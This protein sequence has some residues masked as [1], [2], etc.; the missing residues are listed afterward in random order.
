M[1]TPSSSTAIARPAI[2]A[3][4]QVLDERYRILSLLAEGGMGTVFL[5]EHVLIKRRV[6]IK[7]LHRELA[8]DSAMVQRFMN[9]AL[10]AGTLGHPNI[11]ESTDMGFTPDRVPYIV[12]EYLEGSLLTEEIYRVHG[13][14]IR[15]ALR[16]AIQ[17]AS[18]LDAAHNAG[19]VHLDLKSDNVFLT[20]KD[21]ELDHV[22]VLDFGISRFM[23]PDRDTTQRGLILGTPEFMAPEQVESPDTVDH[24]ADVY[25]LGVLLYE[26]LG[27]RR[28]FAGDDP[29]ILLYRICNEPPPRLER[30]D[31]MPELEHVLFD[32]MLAKQRDARFSSMKEVSS[33]LED[34]LHSV[35]AS[36]SLSTRIPTQSATL[37]VTPAPLP[38]ASLPTAPQ[39]SRVPAMLAI[40]AVLGVLAGGALQF[41]GSRLGSST[42]DAARAALQ[43]DAEDI[44]AL[45]ASQARAARTRADSLATTP[46]L[47]AAIETDA[48]TIADLIRD[49]ALFQPVTGQVLE[50]FLLREG[51]QTS[52]L[53]LPAT[54]PPIP[55]QTGT[56]FESRADGLWVIAYAP[57]AQRSGEIGGTL[58]IASAIDLASVKRRLGEN[59]VA[60][61]LVGLGATLELVASSATAKGT[62][63][64]LPLV[65]PRELKREVAPSLH[66]MAPQ[67]T[68]G[69][70]FRLASFACFGG[71]GLLLALSVLTRIAGRRR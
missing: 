8:H 28:P 65:A 51:A 39:R 24:R 50:L 23:E 13:L 49:G 66:A 29:R 11:V 57:V 47:R 43:A 18:A 2:V 55:S 46:V 17:V 35:R 32:R 64:I 10:A 22:K 54:A 12:Y 9:E 25:A 26:M 3:Q 1:S 63:V 52:V 48:T 33:A 53:R 38:R 31:L 61:Q 20:D 62:P 27:S 45:L 5:A 42:S 60:A 16:I 68:S 70:T 34:L 56:R 69:N 6:A 30:A 14:S 40:G 4:G 58:A 59:A 44:S 71:A 37:L 7:V 36:D 41:G 15:R 21:G 67:L 19:I